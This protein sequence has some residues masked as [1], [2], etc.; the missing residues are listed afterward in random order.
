MSF[1]L[2][3]SSDKRVTAQYNNTVKT[4]NFLSRSNVVRNV[5]RTLQSGSAI[6]GKNCL[7]DGYHSTID[8]VFKIGFKIIFKL[9]IGHRELQDADNEMSQQSEFTFS[10]SQYFKNCSYLNCT[11]PIIYFYQC[12]FSMR[13]QTHENRLKRSLSFHFIGNA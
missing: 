9:S 7:L 5:I 4:V 10:C 1:T 13:R 8:S 3:G 2:N 11:L 12:F 6:F